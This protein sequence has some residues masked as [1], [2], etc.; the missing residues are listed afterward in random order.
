MKY[1]KPFL[2]TSSASS[3]CK[4]PHILTSC[5]EHDS[6]LNP[7]KELEREGRVD[8]TYISVSKEYGLVD[9]DDLIKEIR[10]ETVLVTLMMANNETGV[11]QVSFLLLVAS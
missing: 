1:Q 8:V 5:I 10:D 2:F 9:P 4:K 11:I 7:L 3:N 6:I